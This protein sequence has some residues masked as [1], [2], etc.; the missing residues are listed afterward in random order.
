VIEEDR[1]NKFSRDKGVNHMTKIYVVTSGSYSDY[2][3]EGI[4]STEEKANKYID[5]MVGGKDRSDDFRVEEH[6]LDT[7]IPVMPLNHNSY[8]VSMAK[9]GSVSV[10]NPSSYADF[11]SRMGGVRMCMQTYAWGNIKVGTEYLVTI[12]LA[13]DEQ[14]AVKIAS[15]RR[16]RILANNLW[17]TEQGKNVVN[18]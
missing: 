7:E 9:D 13:T 4:F 17:S 14:H 11:L 8:E 3:I 1:G 10:V 5:F 15:E 2:C 16:S 6:D 12:V 18:V